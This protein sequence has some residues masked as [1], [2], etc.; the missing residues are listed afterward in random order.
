MG[1]N[2]D[3]ND[4]VLKAEHLT[5]RYPIKKGLFGKSRQFVHALEDVSFE[6][7]RGETFAIVGESGCGKSTTG[8]CV[9]RLTEPTEGT[10]TL[11]GEDFTA[12]SGDA[13]VRARQKM[14][15]IFQDPYSS[16]NPRM[17]VADIIAE[18]ID[19]AGTYKTKAE[20]D[21]RVEEVMGAVGL[22]L[23]YKYRYPHEF[24]G[25][26]RQRIGIARAIVLEPEVVV[27]DEPVSAL[28]V[29]VQA[30]VINLLER[31]QDDLG[32]SYVFI[33]HD[34]SVVKH[35]SDTVMVMYLGHEMEL[36]EKDALFERPL[37]PYTQALLDVIPRIRHERIQDKRILQGDVPS[38]TNPPEGCV[39][40]TRCSRCMRVCTEVAPELREVEPG[41]LCACHLFDEALSEAERELVG[42][43][44][45]A[46]TQA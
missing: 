3:M 29:S 2:R 7:H 9:L 14:K 30:K 31:L 11:D 4:V 45:E 27:C 44:P 38:P 21:A 8:K 20:R 43:A 25:G 28:D 18:P 41:H 19:I 33:S 22:D 46:K 37:H 13:L 12:L 35:I 34:L 6:L 1:R 23:S 15:L 26:Q 40:H 24:S 42:I 16:L 17:T 10:V 39:F 5:K 36:A 32:L